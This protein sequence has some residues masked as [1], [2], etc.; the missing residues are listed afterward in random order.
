MD[1]LLNDDEICKACPAVNMR[2]T[3]HVQLRCRP[4]KC[5]VITDFKGIAK[6][7]LAKDDAEW[8]EWLRQSLTECDYGHDKPTYCMTKKAF[9]ERKKEIND[10]P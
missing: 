4:N 1:R 5:L 9:T 2:T 6:A 3:E 7:Q 8:V 10:I